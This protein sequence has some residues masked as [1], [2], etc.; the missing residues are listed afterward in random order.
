MNAESDVF[1]FKNQ[2]KEAASW[3][4]LKS[5]RFTEFGDKESHTIDDCISTS[6][7]LCPSA[8]EFF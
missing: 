3:T 1:A 7:E 2:C 5:D 4:L 6:M 8:D